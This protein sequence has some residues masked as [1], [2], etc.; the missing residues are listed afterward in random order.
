MSQ[1]ELAAVLG[2]APSRVVALI[3]D[4][5]AIGLVERRRST[6]D[7]R[8]SELYT[9]DAARAQLTRIRKIV[10]DHDRWVTAALTEAEQRQLLEL[11]GKVAPEPAPD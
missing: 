8:V 7:R 2:I 5:E 11:L 6:R 1:Q 4:L 3:D 10:R 9:P